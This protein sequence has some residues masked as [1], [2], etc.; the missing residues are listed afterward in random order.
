MH[1]HKTGTDQTKF[2]AQ[3][4]KLIWCIRQAYEVR[5]DPL[6]VVERFLQWIG[7]H[8]PRPRRIHVVVI[9]IE[10]EKESLVQRSRIDRHLFLYEYRTAGEPLWT[11]F[12]TSP[13]G[14]CSDSALHEISLDPVQRRFYEALANNPKPGGDQTLMKGYIGELFEQQ[15]E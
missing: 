7:V 4:T 1:V 9:G 11:Y 3:H 14:E 2:D 15:T 13:F 5:P 12:D 6:S 10:L 8:Q